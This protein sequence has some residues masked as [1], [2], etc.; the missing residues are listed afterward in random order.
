MNQQE[1]RAFLDRE[2]V[3]RAWYALEGDRPG[4][5][6]TTLERVG[7]AWEVFF[8]ERGV[9]IVL[10]RYDTQDEACDFIAAEM[11][12]DKSE[13]SVPPERRGSST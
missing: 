11:V 6:A 12:K 4:Y 13:S 7:D 1:L 2:G 3:P 10:G 5:E 8:I 9:R